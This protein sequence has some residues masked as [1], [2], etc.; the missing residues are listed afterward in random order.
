MSPLPTLSQCYSLLLQE[1]N[2]RSLAVTSQNSQDLK[3]Q[4]VC[5]YCHITGHT[6]AQCYCIHG[7]P[8]RHKLFRK[9]KPKPRFNNANVKHS[10]A[11]NVIGT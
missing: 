8:S 4:L 2:Q 11:A 3:E 7:F 5:D 10:L 9:P 1:E 6:K